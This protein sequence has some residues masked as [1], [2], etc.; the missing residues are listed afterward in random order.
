MRVA[1]TLPAEE[2]FIVSIGVPH[3]AKDAHCKRALRL[4]QMHGFLAAPTSGD[5]ILELAKR[6]QLARE[7][8]SNEGEE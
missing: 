7:I 4:L 1:K 5:A 8:E 3:K 2:A 6:E